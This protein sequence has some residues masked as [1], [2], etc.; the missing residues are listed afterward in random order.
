MHNGNFQDRGEMTPGF[1]GFV[2]S[3]GTLQ[4]AT[5]SLAAGMTVDM[6]SRHHSPKI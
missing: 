1:R 5:S 4:P 2:G 3:G 6:L